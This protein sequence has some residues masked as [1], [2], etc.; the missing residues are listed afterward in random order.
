V[1]GAHPSRTSRPSRNSLP[2]SRARSG[3][4]LESA[5]RTMVAL[6]IDDVL[7]RPE[8]AGVNAPPST[9]AKASGAARGE[10]D[11]AIADDQQ[12]LVQGIE[13]VGRCLELERGSTRLS[14][15]QPEPRMPTMRARSSGI[16]CGRSRTRYGS[17]EASNDSRR[18]LP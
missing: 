13:L 3:D 11:M 5:S 9:N 15:C 16:C 2:R 12:I 7:K 1:R 4:A 17:R 6:L 14:R 18:S 10:G 8:F